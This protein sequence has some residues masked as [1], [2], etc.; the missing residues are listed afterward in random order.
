MSIIEGNIELSQTTTIKTLK[1]T[2]NIGI[3]QY[4]QSNCGE[5]DDVINIILL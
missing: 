1:T 5:L 3:C 2:P 4:K